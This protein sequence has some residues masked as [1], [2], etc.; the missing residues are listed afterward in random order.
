MI[1]KKVDQL[2]EL[3]LVPFVPPVWMR[4][5]YLSSYIMVSGQTP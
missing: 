5:I 3:T 2:L 1:N 4:S